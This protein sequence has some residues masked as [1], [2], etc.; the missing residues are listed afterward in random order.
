MA[1]VSTTVTTFGNDLVDDLVKL[2]NI[3]TQASTW[4]FAQAD[5]I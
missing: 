2:K 3:P 5:L 1:I 4:E